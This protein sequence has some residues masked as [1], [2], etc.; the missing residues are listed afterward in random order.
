[1]LIRI[2]AQ[3]ADTTDPLR[4]FVALAASRRRGKRQSRKTYHRNATQFSLSFLAVTHTEKRRKLPEELRVFTTYHTYGTNC[5][6]IRVTTN[7]ICISRNA[8]FCI[9]RVQMENKAAHSER[10][11][12]HCMASLSVAVS[13]ADRRKRAGKRASERAIYIRARHRFCPRRCE[14]A[15]AE[16][17]LHGGL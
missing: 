17:A 6:K 9:V 14:E 4:F 7:P 3:P 5:K 13:R 8:L 15:D 11:H 2:R 16:A 10:N 1:M 12:A